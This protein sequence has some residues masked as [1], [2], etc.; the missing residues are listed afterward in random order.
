MSVTQDYKFITLNRA[1]TFAIVRGLRARVQFFE[2]QLMETG[3]ETGRSAVFEFE[4]NEYARQQI[5][6]ANLLITMVQHTPFVT[7]LNGEG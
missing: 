1:Q 6:L 3:A 2:L 5:E 7:P 4:A